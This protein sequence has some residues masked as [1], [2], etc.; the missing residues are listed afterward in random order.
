[1]IQTDYRFKK[2]AQVHACMSGAKRHITGSS[3]HGL[4]YGV[5]V[6]GDPL[7]VMKVS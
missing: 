7:S 5:S 6:L 4:L 2:Y 1:M 3:E